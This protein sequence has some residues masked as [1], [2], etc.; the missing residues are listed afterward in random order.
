MDMYHNITQIIHYTNNWNPPAGVKEGRCEDAFNGKFLR[1]SYYWC[2][3]NITYVNFVWFACIREEHK[4][5]IG[6]R[7]SVGQSN[8]VDARQKPMHCLAYKL[9][10]VAVLRTVGRRIG[11][12]ELFILYPESP[13]KRTDTTILA[14]CTSPSS[15]RN[16]PNILIP[17]SPW[18][19]RRT[20]A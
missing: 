18:P 11:C 7:W 15:L 13:N 17:S 10:K 6:N 8:R 9:Q 14:Y 4:E 2:F 12:K 19:F 16:Y 20:G 5:T 1:A 3:I